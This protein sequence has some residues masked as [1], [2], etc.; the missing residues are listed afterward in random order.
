MNQFLVIMLIQLALVLI[1]IVCGFAFFH[2]RRRHDE[3]ASIQ[4]LIYHI[5][6][7]KDVR[8]DALSTLI[9]QAYGRKGEELKNII[10]Q[11]YSKEADCYRELIALFMNRDPEQI[12]KMYQA[13]QKVTSAYEGIL[14][15]FQPANKD[16][17]NFSS[18]SQPISSSTSEPLIDN[19]LAPA[20]S[21]IAAEQIKVA[22]NAPAAPAQEPAVAT[23]TVATET[24]QVDKAM[25]TSSTTAVQGVTQDAAAQAP[26][27]AAKSAVVPAAKVAESE[28]V[29]A[30]AVAGEINSPDKGIDYY[31]DKLMT[32]LET[33]Q[34]N[35][36][37]VYELLDKDNPAKVAKE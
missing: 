21:P 8:V 14:L 18:R 23:N 3:D 17:A 1:C 5:N 30:S 7:H 29:P 24:E 6:S 36:S 32:Y 12:T 4:M 31:Q 13:V 28:A 37:Q 16:N 20:V 10:D 15:Q 25:G 27:I 22:P 34:V 33:K 35:K 2:Y 11:L 9:E 19:I 26:A